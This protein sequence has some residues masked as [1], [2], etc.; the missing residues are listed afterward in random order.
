META[1]AVLP[2]DFQNKGATTTMTLLFIILVNFLSLKDLIGEF[3]WLHEIFLS[4]YALSI[5][6][7]ICCLFAALANIATK[8]CASV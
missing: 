3:I 5:N 7:F 1:L 6:K 4:P 8:F 2:P